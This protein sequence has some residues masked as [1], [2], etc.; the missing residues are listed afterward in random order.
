MQAIRPV[1]VADAF[2]RVLL[3]SARVSF[4]LSKP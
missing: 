3:T 1:S 4:M 2:G